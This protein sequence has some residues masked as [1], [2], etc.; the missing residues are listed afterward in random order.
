VIGLDE[1]D[2]SNGLR[3]VAR[4]DLRQGYAMIEP[5][6]IMPIDEY[7]ARVQETRE[8]WRVILIP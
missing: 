6:G 7:E 8:K 5:S 3:A 1:V 4:E 2:L